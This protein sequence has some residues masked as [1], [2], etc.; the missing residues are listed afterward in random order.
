MTQ[1]MKSKVPEFMGDTESWALCVYTYLT[2][3]HSDCTIFDLNRL[4]DVNL[5]NCVKFMSISL[6]LTPIKD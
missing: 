1:D 5:E 4:E 2:S 3:N 6:D